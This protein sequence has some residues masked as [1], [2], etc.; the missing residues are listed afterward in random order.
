MIAD[1]YSDLLYTENQ[2]CGLG[3]TFT[4]FHFYDPSL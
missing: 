3:Y 4:V 2:A 1:F